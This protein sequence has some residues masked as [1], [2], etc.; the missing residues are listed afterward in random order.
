VRI[1]VRIDRLVLEGIA[2]APHGRARVR[3]AVES[4]IA[5]L[6]TARAAARPNGGAVPSLAAPAIRFA[7]ADRP[8]LLGR[9]I[10]GSVH[11]AIADVTR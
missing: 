8:E 6:I 5:R 3:A 11:A 7:P 9:R 2:L 4:E 1:V 10:A